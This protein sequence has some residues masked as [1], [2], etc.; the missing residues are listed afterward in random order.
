VMT[1]PRASLNLPDG[2]PSRGKYLL[3]F[4]KFWKKDQ[5]DEI[6][7]KDDRKPGW[8]ELKKWLKGR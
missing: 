7:R 3:E 1:R 2:F 8:F 5:R 4:L 6:W